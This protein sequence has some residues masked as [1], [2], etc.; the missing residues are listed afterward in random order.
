LILQPVMILSSV[1]DIGMEEKYACQ[2]KKD[3]LVF[4]NKEEVGK[5]DFEKITT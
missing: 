1:C 3:V 4:N 5:H 2:N